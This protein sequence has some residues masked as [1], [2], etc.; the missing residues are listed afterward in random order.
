[1]RGDLF[2]CRSSCRCEHAFSHLSSCS[3]EDPFS[4]RLLA[5]IRSRDSSRARMMQWP[6]G[7]WPRHIFASALLLAAWCVSCDRS[8]P[9][10][11]PLPSVPP[12]PAASSPDRSI[13]VVLIREAGDCVIA[14]GEPFDVLDGKRGVVLG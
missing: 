3:C 6:G 14:I 13:R 11:D 10:G 1:R 8:P 5:G 12:A 2:P 7:G 4:H 9:P